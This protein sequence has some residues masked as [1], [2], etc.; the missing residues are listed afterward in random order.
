MIMDEQRPTERNELPVCT[1]CRAA[2][3]KLCEKAD[4]VT[5]TC[6]CERGY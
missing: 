1:M 4:G 5:C 3:H 6:N 2:L